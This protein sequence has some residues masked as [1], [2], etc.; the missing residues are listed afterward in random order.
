MDII[1]RFDPAN[2][3]KAHGDTILAGAVLPDGL[4]SPF[5]HAWGYL[6]GPGAMEPHTHHKEEVYIFTKGNGYVVV[7]DAF[8][9]VGP[10]DVAYIPPDSLHSVINESEGELMWAAFWW[11][12]IAPR[13]RNGSPDKEENHD[14]CD[15][16]ND[17]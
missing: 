2:A 10:G 15:V 16:F 11:D 4:H 13:E 9:P 5:D 3:Q 14:E 1:S 17:R 6:N 7:D 8:Y 12:F